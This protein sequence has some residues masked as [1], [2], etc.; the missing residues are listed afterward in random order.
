MMMQKK[1]GKYIRG[2]KIVGNRNQIKEYARYYDIDEI[3]FAI[4][5]A[6]QDT[7]REILNICKETNCNLKIIP[8]CIR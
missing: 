1:V 7:K 4:P 5:S 6:S 8:V 2:V 3:I